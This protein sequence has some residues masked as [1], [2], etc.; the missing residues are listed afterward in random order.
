MKLL[1]VLAL[2]AV[3][4]THVSFAANASSFVTGL[5]SG[6]G[7]T[8]G[9]IPLNNILSGQGTGEQSLLNVSLLIML[10]MLFVVAIIYMFSYVL[11]LGLLKNMA[12]TEMG[13]VAITAIIV[14]IFLGTFNIA[15]A[16]V[17]ATNVF[18]IGNNSV[19]RN[20]YTTDCAYMGATSI[21]LI[22]PLIILN[23]IRL[24]VGTVT[25]L[26]INIEPA[27]FGFEIQP[28]QGY[29]LFDTILGIIDD[30]LGS[31]ITV[32]LGVLVFMGLIYGLFP[33]FL[34]A[35]IILRT[36]PWTRAAGGAFLGLFIG[37]Y[38]V[39]P[40]LLHLMLAGYIAALPPTTLGTNSSLITAYVS[41]LAAGSSV[42]GSSFLTDTST[43]MT[44]L[45]TK[46]GIL[47]NSGLIGY[48]LQQDVEPAAYTIVAIV[49]S[50]ILSFDFAQA[51]GNLLGAPSISASS[52]LN[53]RYAKVI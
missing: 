39:F 41:G 48:Y 27:Y 28:L 22:T 42:S 13:E 51:A 45:A 37:F 44:T 25:S 4:V 34:Y 35:G 3:L 32:I 9:I 11:N 2:A 15:A 40:L 23:F 30:I 14:L 1:L 49:I 50:F 26:K 53:S 17:S 20:L 33:I 16:G 38:L 52:I 6:T 29:G 10:T 31:F 21:D 5:C 7:T 36:M 43:F 47:A 19:G 24:A 8:G 12:K 46:V 18:H